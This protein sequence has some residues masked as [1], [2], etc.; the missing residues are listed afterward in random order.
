MLNP[1]VEESPEATKAHNSAK[2][3]RTDEDDGSAERSTEGEANILKP[4]EV[5]T[6]DELW[7]E[8]GN[9]VLVAEEIAFRVFRGVLSSASL[10]LRDMLVAPQPGMMYEGCPVVYLTDRADD[11]ANF[12]KVLFQGYRMY[13][14]PTDH[15]S[16]ATIRGTLRLGHN[17]HIPALVEAGR[18]ELS[19]RFPSKLSKWLKRDSFC[20]GEPE[21]IIAMAN[22]ART[23]GWADIHVRALYECC[24]LPADL[25]VA[26]AGEGE[27]KLNTEDLVAVIEGREVLF[28]LNAQLFSS[29]FSKSAHKECDAQRKKVRWKLCKHAASR[30]CLESYNTW[31]R[32]VCEKYEMCERC[33]E[34][35]VEAHA[36]ARAEVL[37]SLHIHLKVDLGRGTESPGVDDEEEDDEEVE[38]ES[39]EDEEDNEEENEDDEEDMDAADEST[40][41]TVTADSSVK[42]EIIDGDSPDD[43]VMTY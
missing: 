7:F 33:V 17:Y 27:E 29:V 14:P 23:L 34:G 15:R 21:D 9:V 12:L 20:P 5:T 24:Q 32:E 16:W 11:V 26:G 8:D 42:A 43:T 28:K 41:N 18:V 39:A 3:R 22:T 31:I 4:D 35:H 36:V 30:D 40:P 25:L 10:V 6:H 37:R 38:N 1:R 19:R 13:A 2:R